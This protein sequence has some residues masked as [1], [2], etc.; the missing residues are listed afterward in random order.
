MIAV[1]RGL[2]GFAVAG[3]GLGE[4]VVTLIRIEL[5]VILLLLLALEESTDLVQ[6]AVSAL[7]AVVLVL[8]AAV[9]PRHAFGEFKLVVIETNLVGGTL[10]LVAVLMPVII[11]C[12]GTTQLGDEIVPDA[13]N[14]VDMDAHD[15]HKRIQA[16]DREH[17]HR[18][19]FG[20]APGERRADDIGKQTAGLLHRG[21]VETLRLGSEL[22]VENRTDRPEQHHQSDDH[23]RIPRPAAGM[24]YQPYRHREQEHRQ[25]DAHQA[26][27]TG[28]EGMQED[29]ERPLHAEPFGRA[30]HHAQH[31][32][33]EAQAVALVGGIVLPCA[34]RR[35]HKVP[36]TAWNR[37]QNRF[38]QRL[39]FLVIVVPRLGRCALAGVLPAAR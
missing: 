16:D 5:R 36:Q 34:R 30:E 32:H 20:K 39:L 13:G 38:P 11:R 25:H 37:H 12:L 31:H 29:A 6:E 28:G 3:C 7:F 18:E 17:D 1:Q 22:N 26:E 15:Q 33:H 24:A 19:R 23:T 9:M 10:R 8:V 14:V 4:G 2:R 35:A 21:D 27:G